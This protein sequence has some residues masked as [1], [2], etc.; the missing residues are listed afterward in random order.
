MRC[1]GL[2]V[3]W[4]LSCFLFAFLLQ[5]HPASAADQNPAVDDKALVEQQPAADA[6]HRLNLQPH[7]DSSTLEVVPQ[8]QGVAPPP[9]S[10]TDDATRTYRPSDDLAI[11][12]ATTQR[13]GNDEHRA[14]LGVELE[15]TT[16]CLLGGE[17][18]GFEVVNVWPN[19][20]AERAGIQ[21]RKPST[22][23]GDLETIGSLIAFPVALFTVP[24]LRR[25]GAL[26]VAGD[27][28][29]AVNDRRVR[30]ERELR[31]ELDS[32]RAGDTVY[33]TVIRAIVGGGH[34]TLRIALR[35]EETIASP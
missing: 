23:L 27:I 19:S 22:P 15:Y 11:D 9:A 12:N 31:R 26:G 5:P 24:R 30:T 17:I 35:A 6:E 3:R 16:Q 32:L 1:V 20:P 18:H 29:V 13:S 33:L 28:I 7:P 25:S 8:P 10:S 2:A 14:H 21:A 34:Q 4:L